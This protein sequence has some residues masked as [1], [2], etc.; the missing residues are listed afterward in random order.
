LG[1]RVIVR[2]NSSFETEILAL[3]PHDPDSHQFHPVDNVSHLTPY[4]M[5]LS[6]LGSCTAIVL[7]T[8][9]Q[10]HGVILREVELRLQYDRVFADDCVECEDIQEYKE[11]I[12]E[13]I[14][15]IGDLTPE[16]RKRLFL[17]SRHCPIHK[18]LMQGIEVKSH[19]EE[20]QFL[21][22]ASTR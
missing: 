13:E 14:V 7:H 18:M 20:E 4:G 19:L 17:V 15:L 21:H 12:E 22:V 9:A 11:Q 3:D 8:Y 16:E 6:G 10:H 1:E 5:L 2:Q